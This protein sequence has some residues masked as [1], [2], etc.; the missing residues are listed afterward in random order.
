MWWLAGRRQKEQ[1]AGWRWAP[2]SFFA[3]LRFARLPSITGQTHLICRALLVHGG[4]VAQR[5]Q[6]PSNR[7]TSNLPVGSSIPVFL[8]I[9]NVEIMLKS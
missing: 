7:S 4:E 8:A 5:Q 1:G 9:V 3:A 2:G 6:R